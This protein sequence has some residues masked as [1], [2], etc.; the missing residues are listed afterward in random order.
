M[1]V[2][3]PVPPKL[4]ITGVKHLIAVGSGKGGVG[5]TTVFGQPGGGASFGRGIRPV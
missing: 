2:N 1:T 5:K 3:Q 4:P